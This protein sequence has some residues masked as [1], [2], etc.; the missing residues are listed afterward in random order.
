MALTLLPGVFQL[1]SFLAD[2]GVGRLP[3]MGWRSWNLYH[4]DISDA[5]IRAQID[6]LVRPRANGA[7]LL[8]L[9]Y[10]SVGIDEGWEGWVVNGTQ[11]PEGCTGPNATGGHS[12]WPNG[13]PAVAPSFPDLGGLVSYGHS[14]NVQMGW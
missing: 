14:K 12:H 5:K 4:A 6:A 10:S 8:S 9:G 3:S 2:N 13:T 11:L 1:I 7:S